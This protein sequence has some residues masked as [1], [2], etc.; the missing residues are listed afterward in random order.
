MFHLESDSA[1]A[2][3][4]SKA[5]WIISLIFMEVSDLPN[6]VTQAIQDEYQG[7]KIILAA[8]YLDPEFDGYGAAFVY[9]KTRWGAQIS[10]EGAIIRRSMTSEGFDF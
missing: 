5:N 4:D 6:E 10:K 3:Y 7:A 2:R 1:T 8:R 9:K